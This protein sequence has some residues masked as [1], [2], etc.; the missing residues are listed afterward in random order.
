[1]GNLSLASGR[2][3]LLNYQGGTGLILTRRW[4]AVVCRHISFVPMCV[5]VSL[6][7]SL[8]T[9]RADIGAKCCL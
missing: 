3:A 7:L 9:L 2:E 8:I 5:E 6:Y 1:M 4:D